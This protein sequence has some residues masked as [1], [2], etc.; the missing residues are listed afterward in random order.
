MDLPEWVQR[1][2]RDYVPPPTGKVLITVEQYKGGVTKV[3]IGGMV[4]VK[5]PEKA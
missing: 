4:R 5:P 1:V 3:E 2:I